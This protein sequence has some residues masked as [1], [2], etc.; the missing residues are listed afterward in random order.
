MSERGRNKHMPEGERDKADPVFVGAATIRKSY[1]V[2]AS[3][4]RGWADNG[5][6]DAIRSRG[7]SG[8]RLYRL[9]DVHRQLGV[10]RQLAARPEVARRRICYARA[11]SANQ[12][13][14]LERQCADL[15]AACPSH[16]LITDTSSGLDW[17]RPGLLSL[18][19]AVCSGAV[20]E[21]VVARRDRLAR[22]GVELLEWLFQRYDT[23]LE[24]LS[25]DIDQNDTEELRDDLHAVVTFFVARTSVKRGTSSRKRRATARQ[26]GQEGG[27]RQAKNRKAV[28]GSRL[29]QAPAGG[30]SRGP[31]S[32]P[33]GEEA[34]R[35]DRQRWQIQG[36]ERLDEENAL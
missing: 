26:Q 36:E 35:P 28:Q 31:E 9:A 12:D 13:A 5:T 17:E 33:Q 16:E 10:H 21:V 18:L 30:A 4:L 14:E 29:A 24:V 3:T 19:D 32:Q 27:E 8:K 7:G 25:Q 1:D 6:I 22:I 2:S 20:A 11:S 23:R 34:S 15:R